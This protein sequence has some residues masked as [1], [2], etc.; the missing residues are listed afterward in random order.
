MEEEGEEVN[1]KQVNNLNQ[2]LKHKWMEYIYPNKKRDLTKSSWN[3][4]SYRYSFVSF[5]LLY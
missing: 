2:K 4:S 1:S 5:G 3:Y